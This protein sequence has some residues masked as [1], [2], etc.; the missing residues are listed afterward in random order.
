MKKNYVSEPVPKIT[1]S[2]KDVSYIYGPAPV[3]TLYGCQEVGPYIPIE[4]VSIPTITAWYGTPISLTCPKCGNEFSAD[5][6]NIK[7]GT[8][9]CPTCKCKC[10]IT[11]EPIE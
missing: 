9:T 11:L 7:N 2:W 5:Q 10:K 1:N 6:L 8:L 3:V 4:P